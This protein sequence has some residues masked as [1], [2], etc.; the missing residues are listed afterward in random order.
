MRSASTALWVRNRTT[1]SPR[2]TPPLGP[3][4]VA[5]LIGYSRGLVLVPALLAA[6]AAAL[7]H[8]AA[9]PVALAAALALTAIAVALA[10]STDQ[11]H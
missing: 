2:S 5:Q 11:K 9:W 1:L 7:L 10:I 3:V 6:P 8:P 4:P